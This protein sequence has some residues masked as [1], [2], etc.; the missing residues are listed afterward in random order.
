L[1]GRIGDPQSWNAFAYVANNPLIMIDPTGT[2]GINSNPF[3][4]TGSNPCDNLGPRC[5]VQVND[6]ETKDYI[7][8][9]KSKDPEFAE[10]YDELDS[11][12]E[13]IIL[14]VVNNSDDIYIDSNEKGKTGEREA[15]MI[16]DRNDLN[17]LADDA[18]D[19]YTL[20][21]P[22][23]ILHAIEEGYLIAAGGDPTE[24]HQSAIAGQN[25]YRRKKGRDEIVPNGIWFDES[26]R[27]MSIEFKTGVTAKIEWMHRIMMFYKP[28]Q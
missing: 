28:T 11:K 8:D 24:A 4:P 3:N 2:Y 26:S 9:Q 6:K 14:E 25:R 17:Q 15:T 1:P 18:Q 20:T 22:E 10:Q 27:T 19:P 21:K 7:D 13:V 12:Q 5:V 23:A 16:L